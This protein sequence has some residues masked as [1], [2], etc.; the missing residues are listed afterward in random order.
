MRL[1][2][3]ILLWVLVTGAVSTFARLSD[4]GSYSPS[5]DTWV[6]LPDATADGSVIFA[7]NSDRPP[8]EAQPLVHILGKQYGDGE[9]VKCT[10][11]EIPQVKETYE[12]IGS[13]IW[14]A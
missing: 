1:K 5:C 11:I 4:Q 7:K 6:A 9:K 10:Y 2:I 13:K 12:H 8:M 3:S 14:W